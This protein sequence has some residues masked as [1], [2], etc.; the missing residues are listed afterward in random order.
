MNK[1]DFDKLSEQERL[2][3]VLEGTAFYACVHKPNMSA[4]KR[5]NSAP[6]Y[7]VNL[8]LDEANQAK[9]ITYG[10]KIHPAD[11]N[12]PMPWVKITRK[13][14]EGKP[15]EA[16][17][18]MVVDSVQKNVPGNV[19]IG[20]GSKVMV[21]FGTYWYQNHGGGVGTTLFKVQIR[22]LIEFNI[23]KDRDL[24]DDT[25]GFVLSS[26]KPEDGQFD[27]PE[28]GKMNDELPF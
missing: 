2:N 7:G 27:E 24:A 8:G 10:L 16:A 26:D 22:E 19:L 1:L 9:A 25:A 17:K 18:P 15:M 12:I 6:Y 3:R 28:S 23:S 4:A 11:D 13:V 21:K 5:F 20:N 14:K